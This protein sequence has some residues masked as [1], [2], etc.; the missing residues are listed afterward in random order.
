MADPYSGGAIVLMRGKR[1]KWAVP[2]DDEGRLRPLGGPDDEVVWRMRAGDKI[3]KLIPAPLEPVAPVAP[4]RLEPAA[5][6]HDYPAAEDDAAATS[7]RFGC[8]CWSGP[9]RSGGPAGVNPLGPCP[10]NLPDRAD[11]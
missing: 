8:G 5:G 1:L 4:R 10:K 9:T 2:L 11:G 7:C 6:G 3:L